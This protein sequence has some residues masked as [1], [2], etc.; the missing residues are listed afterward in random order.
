[1]TESV[2][3]PTIVDVRLPDDFLGGHIDGAINLPYH[4]PATHRHA[5]PRG[6]PVVVVCYLGM[7]SRTV[8][9]RLVAD[10][11]EVVL[12]LDGG[13]KGWRDV[14]AAGSHSA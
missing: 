6:R 13:M 2:E 9:Q 8:A 3:P 11:H 14:M 7:L 4:Q 10:G 5:V 1:M 12:N